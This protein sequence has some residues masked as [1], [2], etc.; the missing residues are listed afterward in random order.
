MRSGAEIELEAGPVEDE[1]RRRLGHPPEDE[2]KIDR[3]SRDRRRERNPIGSRT[4][5]SRRG[6]QFSNKCVRARTPLEKGEDEG[7]RTRGD[8]GDRPEADCCG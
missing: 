3:Q 7:Y 2:D 6:F 4:G 1:W 8:K 5:G